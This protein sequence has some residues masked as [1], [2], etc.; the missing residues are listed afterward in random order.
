[1]NMNNKINNYYI[2]LDILFDNDN[3]NNLTI[4]NQTFNLIVQLLD[5][6]FEDNIDNIIYEIK[7]EINFKNIKN[8]KVG[9][10]FDVEINDLNKTYSFF[11]L[12]DIDKNNKIS[13][14]DYI[15]M[16][17]HLFIPQGKEYS[18]QIKVYRVNS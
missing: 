3:N 2:K 12:V 13:I 16:D 6:T 4:G 8:K 5:V 9:F 15:S 1:M 17:R 14:G 10:V 11:I 18:L 7:K